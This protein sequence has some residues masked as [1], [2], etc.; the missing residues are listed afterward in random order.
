M[1]SVTQEEQFELE[2]WNNTTQP[3]ESSMCIHHKLEIQ[4]HETPNNIAL[5]DK[6]TEFSYKQLN[7]A[8]NA[9]ANIL[10]ANKIDLEDNVV[11]CLDRSIE[12]MISIFGILK[13]GGVYIPV[14]PNYP[15]GR[16]NQI[17]SES[18]P[19]FIITFERY[20]ELYDET[21]AEIIFVDDFIN[22]YPRLINTS[23]K[24][25][26]TSKNLAYTIYTSGTTGNPKGVL[27]E[28]HSVMNRIGWMQ[29]AYPLS[30]NDVL[31]QKTSI[32][33]DVSIWELFWWT[34]AGARLVILPDGD[35]KKPEQLINYINEFNISIIHFV[36]SMFNVFTDVVENGRIEEQIGSLKWIFCSGEKLESRVVSQFYQMTAKLENNTSIVNLYGPTEATVDVSYY[37]CKKEDKTDDIPIGK[38]I[39][40]TEIYII[41]ADCNL[42]PRGQEGE[43]VI[44]GVNLARGYLNQ[45]QLTNEKFINLEVF[46]KIKRAYKTGD[47]AYYNEAGNLIFKGRLDS[48]VKLRGNRI[49]LSE[50]E[51]TI[52]RFEKVSLCVCVLKGQPILS[53]HIIAFVV[54]EKN[55]IVNTEELKR[56]LAIWLPEY[57]IPSKIEIV[58]SLPITIHGKLDRNSLL[59]QTEHNQKLTIQSKLQ[60][61]KTIQSIWAK[62]FNTEDISTENNFFEIGGNSI[63]LIQLINAINNELSI[64]LDII[65]VFEFPTIKLLSKYIK[66][67]I[68]EKKIIDMGKLTLS[69]EKIQKELIDF[70][71]QQFYVDEEDIEVDESLVDSGIIDSIGLI[72]ISSYIEKTYSFKVQNEQMNRENFG[73]VI[74]ITQYIKNEMSS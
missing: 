59:K 7:D 38:P 29:R 58:E 34:F 14:T 61:E 71:C 69:K 54:P 55:K 19:K 25:N 24:I 56:Y 73:S 35:E 51:N 63:V 26:I 65:K 62:L 16:I 11:V 4:A 2:G 48:Q 41:N 40:N 53:A 30:E 6:K 46:G 10:L 3:Y 67:T 52:K 12:L 32:T 39:D 9:L 64:E 49:E 33:F 21:V 68:N 74:K 1:R 50:I 22:N 28:H 18:A 8:S 23:P 36:P 44:C 57:M 27:I 66:D 70:I 31:I 20:Q 42:L 37:E 47:R 5:V 17:L 43:L 15:K 13:S 45:Q 72:E 60:I